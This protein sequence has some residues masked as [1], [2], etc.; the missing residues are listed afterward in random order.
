MT[1]TCQICGGALT[2]YLAAPDPDDLAGPRFTMLRCT[3]CGTGRTTPEMSAAELA[4]FYHAGYF[5]EVGGLLDRPSIGRLRALALRRRLVALQRHCPAPARLLDVGC[6]DGGFLALAAR[7]GYQVQGLELTAAGRDVTSRLGVPVREGNRPHR[8]FA[9]ETRF[10][11]IT[12]WHVLEH[13]P[14]PAELLASCAQVL[15][16]GGWLVLGVPNLDSLQARL[17]RTRWYHLDLPRHQV[18]FTERG[19]VAAVRAAGLEIRA[20]G[21]FSLEYGVF[22]MYQSLANLVTTER[23]LIYRLLRRGTPLWPETA[24]ARR[25]RLHLGLALPL[26]LGPAVLLAVAEALAG[27]GGALL[28]AA[29]RP[30][31]PSA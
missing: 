4:G 22:G 24:A 5:G 15:A 21:H 12:L 26:L 18:H 11:A 27:R 25:D 2:P 9:G 31:T 30:I 17:F 7:A 8:A 16:P 20:T 28:L 29:Q 3:G 23:N 14:A 19:L 10:T 13:D 6:G 1:T